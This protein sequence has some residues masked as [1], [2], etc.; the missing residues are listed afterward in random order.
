VVNYTC[1]KS[2]F[3]FRQTALIMQPSVQCSELHTVDNIAVII[4]DIIVLL[5]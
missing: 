2:W 1:Q 3:I 4:L 5:L